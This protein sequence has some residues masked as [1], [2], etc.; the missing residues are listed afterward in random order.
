MLDKTGQYIY[1]CCCEK[2]LAFFSKQQK[3][4]FPFAFFTRQKKIRKY[5]FFGDQK[6]CNSKTYLDDISAFKKT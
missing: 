4:M 3:Y 6:Y 5:K 1:V 2:C